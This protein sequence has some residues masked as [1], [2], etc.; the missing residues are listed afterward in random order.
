[1]ISDS[2]ESSLGP[3]GRQIHDDEVVVKVGEE[4]VVVVEDERSLYA[5]LCALLFPFMVVRPSLKH[6]FSFHRVYTFYTHVS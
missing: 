6:T 4:E 2:S 1:M 5:R 3:S